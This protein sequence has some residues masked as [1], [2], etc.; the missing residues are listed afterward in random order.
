ME[1][2]ALDG[3]KSCYRVLPLYAGRWNSVENVLLSVTEFFLEKL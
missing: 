1:S 2:E 3:S